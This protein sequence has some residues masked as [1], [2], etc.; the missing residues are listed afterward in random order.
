MFFAAGKK[1]IFHICDSFE[2]LFDPTSNDRARGNEPE[3]SIKPGAYACSEQGVR[4][5][6]SLFNFFQ[7][8]KGWIPAPLKK[9]GTIGFATR[10][11]M[12]IC[13]NRR[14]MPSNFC[15]RGLIPA[16]SWF[17]TIMAG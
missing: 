11:S 3:V 16:A 1:L 14:A 13:S 6:L 4:S 2:E 12:L 10:M 8:H 17:S 7:F 15:G 5:N 9:I